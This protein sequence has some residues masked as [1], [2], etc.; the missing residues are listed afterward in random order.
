M[1]NKRLIDPDLYDIAFDRK[2]VY[3]TMASAL[4]EVLLSI[5][6]VA[7]TALDA[8]TLIGLKRIAEDKAREYEDI[9]TECDRLEKMASK[10]GV[11][12]YDPMG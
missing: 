11:P 5:H 1:S 6:M 12:F 10:A 8:D 2:M 4:N 9:M 7:D 3:D